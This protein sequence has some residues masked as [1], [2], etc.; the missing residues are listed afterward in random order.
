LATGL[1]ILCTGPFTKRI[2][3]FQ[4]LK[5][6]YTG[7]FYIGKTTPC[8]DLEK[9]PD[10]DYPVDHITEDMLLTVSKTFIGEI[11]QVPPIF[12]AVKL[13][14]KPLYIYARKDQE[15]TIKS[16]KINIYEFELTK[17]EM[18]LVE[19]RVVC[20]KGTYI[21]SL[22]RDFGEALGS[23]AY[24]SKLCRTRIGD[25][26]LEDAMTLAELNQEINNPQ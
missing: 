4:D 14:G 3:E 26:R 16:K 1:L 7:A 13:D 22:A 24:L 15:V 12:S 5:K 21:R 10:M 9:E 11:D 23:G 2:E 18:P 8:Y 25:F 17:I 6:E 19:F 20:S